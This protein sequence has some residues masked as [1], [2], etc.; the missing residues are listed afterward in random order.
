MN[1]TYYAHSGKDPKKSDWQRLDDHLIRVATTA[2][3]NA[4]YFNAESL[5]EICGLL[6]DLGKYSKEF[7]LRLEGG[8]RVDHATA[9]ARFAADKWPQLGKL[10]AYVIAG[11]HAG[12]ANGIDPGDGRATLKDRL[13]CTI[14]LLDDV[15]KEEI[16]VPAKLS[17]P[18]FIPA[19]NMQGFQTAFLVRMLYSCLVDAD[20]LDTECFY[21]G[22]E[23]KRQQRGQQPSLKTLRERLDYHLQELS[24]K[25]ADCA[26]E[27]V[28][29]LRGRILKHARTQA[30]LEPGLFSLTVPTGGGKT[31][32]SMAFALD[33]AI[34]HQQR[35]VIYVIPFTSIIEQNAKVFRDLFIQLGEDVV[36]EH[37]ST[38]DD[39]GFGWREETKEKLRLA[40]E[41]WDAPVV[42][43]TAVQFFE[44][45]FADRSSRCR[46]LHNITG[47]VIILDEAQMLPQKLLRPTMAAIDELARNYSCSIVLCTATQP[48]LH[49]DEFHNGFINVREIAPD[50]PQLYRQLDRVSVRHIGIQTDEQLAERLRGS[51]QILLILNNRRHAHSIY[52]GI[53]EGEGYFHL[54]T[55]MCAKHRKAKLEQIRRRL[56]D[57]EA[58]KVVSTSL[59][60]AG[61]DVDFPLVMRAESGLDAIAQAAGRCNREGKQIKETSNVLVFSSP[62][63][64]APPELE[65]QAASMRT[66]FRCHKGDLLA[67]EA[68]KAYFQ[69]LFWRDQERLD[70]KRLLKLHRNHYERLSFPFQTIANEY[71]IIQSSMRP[72]IIPFDKEA[73]QWIERLHHAEFVGRIAKYL[74]PYIVQV[75]EQVFLSLKSAGA[76]AEIGA[77]RFSGQFWELTNA[78]LYDNGVGLSWDDPSH[79]NAELCVIC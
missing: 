55:L 11:H 31:L 30:L 48:A 36:L 8:K 61:I 7:A 29:G 47:S 37:H 76:I 38:F 54:T 60:E 10:L 21:L 71:R 19:D 39:S 49:A 67:P 34:A 18:D 70:T 56:H 35:R 62:D 40:M 51:R 16:S 63:W 79:L 22:L 75:P 23:G 25:H 28:N 68:I 12:L 5:A 33:H 13:E 46:K 43:T 3:A 45:L 50:P 4:K 9:G 52:D 41:N 69:D 42:V 15:W 6:H 73:E 58:C 65:Q 74:Q 26:T 32:T 64:P 57:N 27:S 53:G 1:S 72:V 66:V 44:S 24:A 14:P 20:Y 17:F 59:I 78:R 2:G 77:G